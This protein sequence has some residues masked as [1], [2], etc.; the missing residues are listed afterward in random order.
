MLLPDGWQA[1]HDPE[2]ATCS[3]DPQIGALQISA[4]FKDAEVDAADL[5]DFAAKHLDAG[6]LARPIQ[7]GDFV[8]FSIGF[9]VEATAEASHPDETVEE[10]VAFAE[11][12]R[13]EGP[14]AV[15]IIEV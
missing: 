15:Q 13:L 9:Q 11:Q 6:A 2:C 10:V 7:A 3:G 5:R 1:W 4:A 12:F 8:G 14:S